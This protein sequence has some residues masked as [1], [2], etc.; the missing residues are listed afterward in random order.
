MLRN[1]VW[2]GT[3]AFVVGA[4][5][6]AVAQEPAPPPP[7]PGPAPAPPPPPQTSAAPAAEGPSD[8]DRVVGHVGVTY[9]DV[10]NL[11]IAAPPPNAPPNAGSVSAPVVGVRYWL[12]HNLGLDLG[13]GIGWTSGSN[14]AKVGGTSQTV[15]DPSFPFGFALHAGLPLVYANGQHYAFMIIPETTLGF[16]SQTIKGMNGAPDSTY[17]G[18]LF[19]IGARAGAE[20]QFGFIGIPQLSLTGSIGL[21]FSY[22]QLGYSSGSGAMENSSST[23]IF[24]LATT[25]PPS[26]WA[27][28]TDAI[29]ATY[30]L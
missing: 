20:I 25:V 16:A 2:V 18:A 4:T 12:K 7:P 3:F 11:P 28:F 19:N 26:P 10:T 14:S 6:V 29:S 27:I 1:A 22:Q 13:L 24:N 23:S 21:V 9:F 5:R 17:S 8:H 30:Y 15:A